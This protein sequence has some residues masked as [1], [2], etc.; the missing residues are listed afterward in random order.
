MAEDRKAIHAHVNHVRAR[1]YPAIQINRFPDAKRLI[2]RFE[3]IVGDWEAGRTPDARAIIEGA[4][5]IAVAD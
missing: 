5:E 3:R 1:L 2:V 4:N